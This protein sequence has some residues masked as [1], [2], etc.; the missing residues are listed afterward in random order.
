MIRPSHITF[1]GIDDRTD[2]KRVEALSKKYSIEWGCLF[3]GRL[4]NNRYPSNETVHKFV[5][6]PFVEKAAHLCSDFATTFNSGKWNEG[7]VEGIAYPFELFATFD[8]IQ[9]NMKES[10]YNLKVL[11]RMTKDHPMTLVVQHRKQEWPDFIDGIDFL[12]DQSGGNGKVA[13]KLPKQTNDSQFVGYAGGINPDNVLE[14]I[15][16]IDAV[17]YWIDMETGVRTDDWLDLDKCEAIC[18]KVYS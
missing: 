9:V 11:S 7:F 10:A 2:L 14:V 3:G 6:L 16:R 13:K 17:N 18:K 4:S 5:Q 15:D 12:F 8:R 1:T